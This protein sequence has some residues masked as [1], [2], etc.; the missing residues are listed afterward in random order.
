MLKG[1]GCTLHGVDQ[2]ADLMCEPCV[3]SKHAREPFPVSRSYSTEPLQL[4]HM[5]LCGRAKPPSLGCS[6]YFCTFLDDFSGFSAVV[7]LS[8]KADAV[9]A[10]KVQLRA[11]E[12]QTGYWVRTVRTDNGREFKQLWLDG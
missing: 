11:W 10:V 4:V 2:A 3:K 6:Q 7:L 5:D 9:E 12:R 8:S 1:L